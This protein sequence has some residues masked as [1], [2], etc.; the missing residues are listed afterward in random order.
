MG[1]L[2]KNE[3]RAF[4]KVNGEKTVGPAQAKDLPRRHS[5]GDD[6]CSDLQAFSAHL[7]ERPRPGLGPQH[8]W[9]DTERQEVPLTAGGNDAGSRVRWLWEVV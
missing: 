9:R 8:V 4:L 1:R 2:A 5:R 6:R 7:F 3:R